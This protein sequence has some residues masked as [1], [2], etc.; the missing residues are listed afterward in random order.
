MW[1][2]GGESRPAGQCGQRLACC[3]PCFNAPAGQSGG[4]PE[5][6]QARCLLWSPRLRTTAETFSAAQD[7]PAMDSRDVLPDPPP[8]QVTQRMFLAQ[9]VNVLKNQERC[10]P[11][12]HVCSWPSPWACLNVRVEGERRGIRFNEGGC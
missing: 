6:V 5:R 4:D 2:G 3:C 10:F 12:L 11:H 1:S 9:N 7:T 8:Y